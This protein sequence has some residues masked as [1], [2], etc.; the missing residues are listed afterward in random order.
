VD[1][2][3]AGGFFKLVK[4]GFSAARKQVANSLSHSLGLAKEEV[5]SLL[6]KA[7]IDPQRR[8][9]TFSIEDWVSLWRVFNKAVK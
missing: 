4:A 9:E 7:G 6:E 1:V 5:L 3:D 2:N 8:A